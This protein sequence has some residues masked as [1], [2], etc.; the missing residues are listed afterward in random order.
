LGSEAGV[1]VSPWKKKTARLSAG[2]F[3]DS[4]WYRA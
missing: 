2:G 1:M 4:G 3:L